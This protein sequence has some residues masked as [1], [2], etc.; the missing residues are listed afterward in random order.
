[1]TATSHPVPSQ[2][3]APPGRLF[4]VLG[5]IG[6]TIVTSIAGYWTTSLLAERAA[7]Q[8]ERMAKKNSLEQSAQEL[9]LLLKRL[10]EDAVADRPLQPVK[11]LIEN[12]LLVQGSQVNAARPMLDAEGQLH[13]A[14][15]R[16]R[17]AEYSDALDSF[18]GP[19]RSGG[20]AQ[21][22]GNLLEE[23][24]E[25]LAAMQRAAGIKNEGV[26]GAGPKG[27]D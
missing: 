24:E 10:N 25:M 20:Y 26:A 14:R 2:P 27:T 11:T 12:N 18:E 9:N 7:V 6:T 16:S 19:E 3:S 1:M 13:A 5:F 17:L 22:A 4:L 15:Y 23:Q 8:S 21:A